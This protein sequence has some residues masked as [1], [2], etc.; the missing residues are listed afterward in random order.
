MTRAVLLAGVARLTSKPVSLSIKGASSSGKSFTV[1]AALGLLPPH[2]VLRITGASDRALVFLPSGSLR[3]R[4]V[5]LTE[6]TPIQGDKEHGMLA[7]FIRQLQS[8]GRLDY[9]VTVKN[10][11]GKGFET[12]TVRQD[13]PTGVVVTTTAEELHAENETRQVAVETNDTPEQTRRVLR[14]IADRADTPA[15]DEAEWH[16]LFRWIE[17]GP[18]EAVV[19]FA[20]WLAERADVS[21]VRMRRD[22][23]QLLSLVRAGTLLHSATRDRDGV[24]RVVAT[25]ADYR[26]ALAILEPSAAAG[27]G[28]AVSA[29]VAGAWAA[30][31]K[32]VEAEIRRDTLASLSDEEIAERIT[33]TMVVCS[34]R[35]LGKDMGRDAS[36]AQRHLTAAEKAGVLIVERGASRGATRVGLAVP[37]LPVSTASAGVFP[38]PEDLE[39]SRDEWDAAQA[40]IRTERLLAAMDGPAE[41]DDPSARTA[42]G[43]T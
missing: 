2:A 17:L 3:H 27:A 21:A 13:G 10:D 42:P 24:G 15:V 30:V 36:T 23:D 12:R 19:P 26:A 18:R 4:L 9:V 8:E 1:G 37:S 6:A 34:M 29:A 25:V 7:G 35:E 38:R 33:R 41:E 5:L 14:A 28:L 31:R 43:E 16:A 40:R 32:R 11:D 39:A 22:F 20:A